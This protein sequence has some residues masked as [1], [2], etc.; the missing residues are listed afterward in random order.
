MVDTVTTQILEDGSR[1]AVIKF[2]NVSDA[3]GEAAVTKVTPSSLSGAPTRVSIYR[4]IAS[5]S[6][7]GVNILWDATAD[8]LAWTIPKDSMMDWDFSLIGGIPNNAG[9]GVTGLI[10]FTTIGAAAGA[11][12]S[13]ILYLKKN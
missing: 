3:T 6:V 5:S 4:I 12:Y 13:V 9:A 7:M 2:T 10:Q 11:T 1:N 8:V